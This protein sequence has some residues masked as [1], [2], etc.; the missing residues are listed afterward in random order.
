MEQSP[1]S[2]DDCGRLFFFPPPVPPT[3]RRAGQRPPASP[4]AP[5][6]S[7]FGGLAAD[8]KS[9]M[10]QSPPKNKLAL[11]VRRGLSDVDLTRVASVLWFPRQRTGEAALGAQPPLA[12]ANCGILATEW[13]PQLWSSCCPL[14]RCRLDGT[15]HGCLARLSALCPVHVSVE[16]AVYSTLATAQQQQ[17]RSQ[18]HPTA[19]SDA[20]GRY[21]TSRSTDWKAGPRLVACVRGS[22]RSDDNRS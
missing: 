13:R 18:L 3:L 19:S 2:G 22:V 16:Q 1:E 14:S 6:S 11:S 20:T 21:R 17:P 9:E 8:A 10:G 15:R 7:G 5:G 12:V 4:S